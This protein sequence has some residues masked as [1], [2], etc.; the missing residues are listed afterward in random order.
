MPWAL[1]A[2]PPFDLWLEPMKNIGHYHFLDTHVSNERSEFLFVGVLNLGVPE[3]CVADRRG[4]GGMQMNVYV[5]PKDN[6]L[7][8]KVSL[9]DKSDITRVM[10]L[11]P[12]TL[13]RDVW[14]VSAIEYG[15]SKAGRGGRGR[16]GKSGRHFESRS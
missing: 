11:P 12:T 14:S 2:P 5:T 8:L 4:N 3:I 13:V 16:C 1:Y 9:G 15:D 6:N 10:K 7:L